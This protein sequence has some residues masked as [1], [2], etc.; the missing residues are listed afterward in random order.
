MR[1]L[2]FITVVVCLLALPL[3]AQEGQQANLS[4]GYTLIVKQGHGAQFEAS[5]K[6]HMEWRASQKDPW[7]WEVWELDTGENLGQFVAISGGHGWGDFDSYDLPGASQNWNVTAGPHVAK[8]HG[9]INRMMLR[10]SRPPEGELKEGAL[11]QVETFKFKPGKMQE[12]VGL[13]IKVTEAAKKTNWAGRFIWLAPV[14]GGEGG[15]LTLVVSAENW[16]AMDSPS[17]NVDA[18]L[19]EAIGEE[20]AGKLFEAFGSIVVSSRKEIWRYRADLSISPGRM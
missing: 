11:A 1:K 3:A 12:A 2:V 17:H 18:M 15:T 10:A 8:A 9:W 16:A 6:Q 7:G 19:A 20:A 5:F 14:A 13:I 4:R